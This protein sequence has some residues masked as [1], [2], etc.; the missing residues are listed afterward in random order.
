MMVIL[1]HLIIEM[2]SSLLLTD[3]YKYLKDNGQLTDTDFH[4]VLIEQGLANNNE[5]TLDDFIYGTGYS[6]NPNTG[7]YGGIY[8]GLFAR[9]CCAGKDKEGNYPIN[10]NLSDGYFADVGGSAFTNTDDMKTAFLTE[11]HK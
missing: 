3:L 6:K 1:N 10:Y 11:F 7:T 8:D 5:I 4:Q 2:T 9:F